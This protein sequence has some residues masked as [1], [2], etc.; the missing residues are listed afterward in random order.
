M[1]S[2]CMTNDIEDYFS[3]PA[4]ASKIRHCF[5]ATRNLIR[6]YLVVSLRALAG[7]SCF[8]P[9]N[10]E[11]GFSSLVRLSRDCS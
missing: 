9:V 2:V 10:K 3:A 11:G 1:L 6:P 4:T 5:Q 7:L 8:K